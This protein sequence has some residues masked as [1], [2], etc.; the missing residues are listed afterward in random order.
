MQRAR[1]ILVDCVLATASHPSPASPLDGARLAKRELTD[2]ACRNLRSGSRPFPFLGD[3]RG[4]CD[5]LSVARMFKNDT[6]TLEN[7]VLVEAMART[8]SKRQMHH[9]A[10]YHNPRM[11]KGLQYRGNGGRNADWTRGLGLSNSCPR[12]SLLW[13]EVVSDL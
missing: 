12:G 6:I 3:F 13:L 10:G 2:A 5:S 1:N 11:G 8:S 9:I 4:A 7:I